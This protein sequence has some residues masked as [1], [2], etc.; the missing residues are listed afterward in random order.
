MLPF[1]CKNCHPASVIVSAG[2][3]KLIGTGYKI[4]FLLVGIWH[5]KL[6]EEKDFKKQIILAALQFGGQVLIVISVFSRAEFRKPQ[7]L[8]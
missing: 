1:E 2:R 6:Q 4:F 8:L 3:E 5:Y 7:K